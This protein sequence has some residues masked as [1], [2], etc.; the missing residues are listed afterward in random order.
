MLF[1]C[2][3]EGE[4]CWGFPFFFLFLRRRKR[5]KAT[6]DLVGVE[7]KRSLLEGVSDASLVR[8]CEVANAISS[9]KE[10]DKQ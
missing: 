3:A 8:T 10:L 9:I 7:E 2:S 4:G 6:L 1:P 5:N